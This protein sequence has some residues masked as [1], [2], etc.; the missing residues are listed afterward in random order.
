MLKKNMFRFNNDATS[1]YDGIVVVIG[2]LVSQAYII[3]K[4]VA[5]VWAKTLEEAEY[6]LRTLFKLLETR[7]KH[8]K[9]HPIHGSG[10][11]ATHSSALWM[12]ISSNF[13][14]VT[15]TKQ[16]EQPFGHLIGN[17]K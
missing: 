10:Q 17:I 16:P 6:K 3:H 14:I 9:L 13:L 15:M 2:S 4:S 1:C 11:G 8:T 12:F 5:E 7:Y